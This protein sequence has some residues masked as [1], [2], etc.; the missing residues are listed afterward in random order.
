MD[1]KFLL[2]KIQSHYQ[3]D[4]HFVFIEDNWVDI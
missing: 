2:D 4:Y 1:L 3:K